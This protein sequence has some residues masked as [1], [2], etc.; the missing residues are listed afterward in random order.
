[1]NSHHLYRED[2]MTPTRILI[3]QR[4]EDLPIHLSR[5]ENSLSFF[6]SPDSNLLQSSD[7]FPA[8]RIGFERECLS[9]E[10]AG[11]AV[12]RSEGSDELSMGEDGEG[13][14]DGAVFR[15]ERSGWLG[16]RFVR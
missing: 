8:F 9:L 13:F 3:Q 11:T 16:S 6:P 4:P 2:S 5:S 7:V 12:G 15:F 1:M 14:R 10:D